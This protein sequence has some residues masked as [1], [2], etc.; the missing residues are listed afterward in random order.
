MELNLGIE[1]DNTNPVI[2]SM[3][4]NL[5]RNHVVDAVTTSGSNLVSSATAKFDTNHTNDMACVFGANVGGA[6][7]N[8]LIA[9]LQYVSATQI[10]F[11]H[12]VTGV[13]LN[14]GAS[15]TSCFMLIA[16]TINSYT[17]ITGQQFLSGLQDM[18]VEECFSLQI[19]VTL[20]TSATKGQVNQIAPYG[21]TSN[22][23]SR[24]VA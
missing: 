13:A 1:T 15:L 14:A 11:L 4:R 20:Q 3:H 10:N 22:M 6:G 17:P 7:I 21:T 2:I 18:L 12:P 19:G 16:H 24:Q 23:A 8:Y 5:R 9:R